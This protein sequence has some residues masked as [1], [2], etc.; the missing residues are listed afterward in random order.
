MEAPT[1]NE[2]VTKLELPCQPPLNCSSR[3]AEYETKSSVDSKIVSA[4]ISVPLVSQD[5]NVESNNPFDDDVVEKVPESSDV[6]LSDNFKVDSTSTFDKS[7][8][9]NGPHQ[10]ITPINP[11]DDSSNETLVKVSTNPFDDE[12]PNVSTNPFD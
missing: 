3:L 7:S 5:Q 11:F 12:T 9:Q 2:F 6:K 8:V 1:K 10:P 4:S